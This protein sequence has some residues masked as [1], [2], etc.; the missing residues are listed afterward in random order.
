MINTS[1]SPNVNSISHRLL[2]LLFS[3]F[4]CFSVLANNAVATTYV[5]IMVDDITVIIPIGDDTDTDGDGVI[6]S[7]D[8]FPNDPT[9]TLDSD[10]DGVG[11]NADA[12]PNDSTETTDSDGNGTG[13][14]AAPPAV[15]E[16]VIVGLTPTRVEES[17]HVDSDIYI[18]SAPQTV[19]VRWSTS[20]VSHVKIR[21][22]GNLTGDY[23]VTNTEYMDDVGNLTSD[24]SQTVSPDG[25]IT[26][27]LQGSA[28]FTIE[29]I[30]QDGRAILDSFPNGGI[31]QRS[32]RLEMWIGSTLTDPDPY[33]DAFSFDPIPLQPVSN[34]VYSNVVNLTGFDGPLIAG[35]RSGA[36]NSIVALSSPEISINGGAYATSH[37]VNPGDTLQIRT[38]SA[39][40]PGMATIAEVRVGGTANYWA[41][42][43]AGTPPGGDSTPDAFSFTSVTVETSQTGYNFSAVITLGGFDGSLAVTISAI[44]DSGGTEL[45]GFAGNGGGFVT[46]WDARAGDTIQV[47]VVGPHHGA[48][49]NTATLT[50][51]NVSG[52]FTVTLVEPGS[53]GG[54]T[55]VESLRAVGVEN[56]NNPIPTAPIFDTVEFVTAAS[57]ILATVS[58]PAPSGELICDNIT[59]DATIGVHY[60]FTI[61]NPGTTTRV[62]FFL[63]KESGELVTLPDST[64]M[65]VSSTATSVTFN[66]Q[67]FLAD[68][69][70]IPVRSYDIVAHFINGNND[71][72][73]IDIFTLRADVIR[74]VELATVVTD[75]S[76]GEPKD[77]FIFAEES[78]TLRIT[79]NSMGDLA[80][81]VTG[82]QLRVGEHVEGTEDGGVFHEF[83]DIDVPNQLEYAIEASDLEMLS[84]ADIPVGTYVIHADAIVDGLVANTNTITFTVFE[85][86]LDPN[87]VFLLGFDDQY[88]VRHGDINGDQLADIY[89][90]RNDQ[91]GFNPG[92]REFALLKQ[93]DGSYAIENL[94]GD[95]KNTALALPELV[96]DLTTGDFNADGVIDIFFKGLNSA[97]GEDLIV[98]APNETGKA[99]IASKVIDDGNEGGIDD[100]FRQFFKDIA[101]YIANSNYFVDNTS[102]SLTTETRTFVDFNAPLACNILDY[103]TEYCVDGPLSIWFVGGPACDGG[104]HQ[105][106]LEFLSSDGCQ[107]PNAE[108]HY[109]DATVTYKVV[110]PEIFSDFAPQTKD[111]SSAL[112]R[113]LANGAI[114]AGLGDEAVIAAI[115]ERYLGVEVFGGVLVDGGKLDDEIGVPDSL[116]GEFRLGSLFDNVLACDAEDADTGLGG[117]SLA[118]VLPVCEAVAGAATT[119]RYAQHI[120][121]FWKLITAFDTE[122]ET[123]CDMEFV[124]ERPSFDGITKT[125]V[126]RT[127]GTLFTFPQ[128][129]GFAC[130]PVDLERCLVDTSFI[131]PPARP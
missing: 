2:P 106:L 63:K 112:E 16:L 62:E 111:F 77:T 130:P 8:A 110:V 78:V 15:D 44:N 100:D 50:V 65:Q 121:R 97:V 56:S 114:N 127:K 131:Q 116:L 115:L 82:I 83:T 75:D 53:G 54:G 89:I 27:N 118:W 26:F 30:D 17:F 3:F 23:S 64:T 22:G 7:E 123:S 39:P 98:Y 103:S 34:V 38:Q 35:V 36:A 40:N 105:S 102:V 88:E 57:R 59:Y 47:R 71:G 6:D 74:L 61:E 90:K 120:Y 107:H 108:I 29:L 99:P 21:V 76:A 19:T 32:K 5:P 20:N 12:F 92:V 13:D 69:F 9:E 51:G 124:Q 49:E 68:D 52:T 122:E 31:W 70:V 126:Y 93:T 41:I 42:V 11:D 104:T 86:G 43:N 101:G 67:D 128:A 80:N 46:S 79:L 25:E 10:G 28:H 117:N 129:V 96:I 91:P 1:S 95:Q 94:F 113:L 85:G 24:P 48:T 109:D 119:T 55:T 45:A 66:T 60:E 84:G 87:A 58:A 14:N 73:I 72:E 18:F 125:C 81:D 4:I 37:V 33:P